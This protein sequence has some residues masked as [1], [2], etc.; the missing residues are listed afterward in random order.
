[1]WNG[2]APRTNPSNVRPSEERRV[3]AWVGKSVV[4]KGDL[5]SSEDMVIDGT[6]EGTITV[7]DHALTL[8]PDADVRAAVVA[9]RVTVH[10]AV[11]GSI[12][13][14]ENV[15]LLETALVEGDIT[16]PRIQIV[17]GARLVGHVNTRD[18]QPDRP[19]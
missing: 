13:A 12:T 7:R 18:S 8:G 2:E 1:M 16:T 9:R 10:G 3:V 5:S 11:R 15:V 14:G 4:F 6:V 17:D 19:R